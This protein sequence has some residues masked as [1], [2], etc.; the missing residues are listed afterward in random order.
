MELY[1]KQK[2]WSVLENYSVVDEHDTVQ[3]F[4]KGQLS[5]LHKRFIVSDAQ[6]VP[7]FTL[8]SRFSF[9]FRKYDIQENKG[10]ESCVGET[11]G[12]FREGF[13]MPFR[14]RAYLKYFDENGVEHKLRVTGSFIGFNWKIKDKSLPK[15]DRT[16]ATIEKKVFK[17]ADTYRLKIINNSVPAKYLLA[18]GILIDTMHHQSH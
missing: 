8:I 7:M 17:V 9:I 18:I 16:V 1:I 4:V 14:R 2:F 12:R 5:F 13:H 11:I 6:Q 15:G 3:F 10:S